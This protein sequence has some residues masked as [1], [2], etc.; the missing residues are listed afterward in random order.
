MTRTIRVPLR[1]RVRVG[2]GLKEQAARL[3][4]F[5]EDPFLLVALVRAVVVET[6]LAAYQRRFLARQ[7]EMRNVIWQGG[8]RSVDK[9]RARLEQLDEAP[10]TI[11][12]AEAEVVAARDPNDPYADF[13]EAFN[14]EL[15]RGVT[16]RGDLFE[17]ASGRR[18]EGAAGS[19]ETSASTPKGLFTS[20]MKE[21]LAQLTR[22]NDIDVLKVSS[23]RIVLGIGRLRKLEK[24]ETPSRSSKARS[25]FRIL[26]RQL[27]FGTGQFAKEGYARKGGSES[28]YKEPNAGG[29]WWFGPSRGRGYLVY[30][31]RPGNFLR[32]AAS[33]PYDEDARR[34]TTVMQQRLAQVIGIR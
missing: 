25:K 4:E 27:E 22:A 31:T 18:P 19:V 17:E 9:A 24:I 15:E 6:I 12:D 8:D 26:L 33:L 21:L 32:T 28:R 30:G 14:E 11:E 23:R 20:R 2:P 1:L 29:A 10:P 7:N 16:N 34:F 3:Q 5:A 13:E